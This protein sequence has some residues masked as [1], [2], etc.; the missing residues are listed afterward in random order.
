MLTRFLRNGL[1]CIRKRRDRVRRRLGLALFDR[2]LRQRGHPE[3]PETW[4][5]IRW[6]GKLGDAFV[7][8][9]IYAEIKR[10]HPKARVEVLTTPEAAWLFRQTPGVDRVHL[11]GRRPSYAA[12]AALARSLG[13]VEVLVHFVRE[14][15]MRDLFFIERL[16]PAHVASLDDCP[17]CVDLKMGART[18]HRHMVDKYADL[19][20]LLGIEVG[21][22]HYSIPS[23]EPQAKALDRIWPSGP[24]IALNPWGAGRARRMT[25]ESLSRL[26]EAVHAGI[27]QARICLLFAPD[28]TAEALAQCKGRPWAFCF[29]QSRHILDVASQ[30]RRSRAVISV[31]TSTVH[32]AVGLDKPLFGLYNP[33]PVTWT[34]W[35]PRHAQAEVVFS[36]EPHPYDIN[37]L[38]WDTLPALLQG[39]WAHKVLRPEGWAC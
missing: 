36:L 12:L 6:D 2:P 27:P 15:K 13:R 7:T 5:F 29:R 28:R 10:H 22:I 25:D 32:L 26:L 21:R 3:V 17:R 20:H 34:D 39:W 24:V 16:G 14:F 33:D 23:S 11:C 38:P 31:D 4:L 1:R 9:W 18:A 30:I 35:A 19:L 37:S 8:S